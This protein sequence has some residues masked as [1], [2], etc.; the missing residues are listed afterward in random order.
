MAGQTLLDADTVLVPPGPETLR[1]RLYFFAAVPL[2]GGNL[3]GTRIRADVEPAAQGLVTGSPATAGVAD[4]VQVAERLTRAD[5][6]VAPPAD[7]SSE[8]CRAT[9]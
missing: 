8:G 9:G 3:T 5:R 4:T 2:R 1:V 7:G 6:V